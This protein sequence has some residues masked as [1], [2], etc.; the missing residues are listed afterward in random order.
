ME[1]LREIGVDARMIVTEKLTD[2]PFVELVTPKWKIMSAFLRE[3]L[4]IFIAN[5]F[6]RATLFKIDTGEIGLPLYKNKF[7]KNADAVLL[8]WVNQGV[9]SLKGIDKI[10]NLGKPVIWTM[11]DMWN[12]TGVCHHAGTCNHYLK[13]CG[14]C[15]LLG[16]CQGKKD[17]SWKVWQ[18]K[19]RLY[20]SLQSKNL[21]FVAV[22]NWLKEKALVSGL[23]KN[24]DIAVIHNPFPSYL[25]PRN[26][27][28]GTRL[29]INILFGAARLDDPIK[30]L[31]ILKKASQIINGEHPEVASKLKL[32]LFGSVK[33]SRSL[34]G[35]QIPMEYVG[36]LRGEDELR[37]IYE[38]G[39][40]LVS[41][42]SYETLP[43]T[44][45]E[46]QAFGLIPVSFNQ[47]GQADI[48]EH[49]S[50]GYLA[51]FNENEDIRAGNLV[52]GILWAYGITQDED[53]L[54]KIRE[55]MRKSVENK[56]SYRNIAERYIKLIENFK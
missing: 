41:A 38:K 2:S 32:V 18:K 24:K 20:D 53:H 30:G 36:M 14:D 3:R 33:D 17:L 35:F 29:P 11:H 8:N 56:F 23:L 1:A 37:D 39:S 27:A 47:G 28:L 50:T 21:R 51:E 5:S 22:S 9:L 16:K 25:N 4:R 31:P 43:G 44:L 10:F 48:I 7:V 49:L 52:E 55:D 45:V 13:D 19:H 15:F 54:N 46:A 42:S 12:M 6:N 40:I 26:P 34:E